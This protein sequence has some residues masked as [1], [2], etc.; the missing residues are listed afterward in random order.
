MKDI[1]PVDWEDVSG[2]PGVYEVEL[3]GFDGGTDATDHLIKW[4]RASSRADV[5][6]QYPGSGISLLDFV[7]PE[8]AIDDTIEPAAEADP[9][10]G[11]NDADPSV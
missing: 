7:P 1:E 10:S 11:L 9:G 8:T 3:P 2:G 5:V 4:V 6:A